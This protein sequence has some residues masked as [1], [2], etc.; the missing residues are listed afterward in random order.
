MMHVCA[1]CICLVLQKKWNGIYICVHSIVDGLLSYC[2][3]CIDCLDCLE[4]M[5]DAMDGMDLF[6]CVAGRPLSSVLRQW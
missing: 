2:L 3:D 4:C 6:D 5:D 1:L